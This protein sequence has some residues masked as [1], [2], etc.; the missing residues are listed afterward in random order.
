MTTGNLVLTTS[1]FPVNSNVW[2]DQ[3]NLQLCRC[4]ECLNCIGLAYVH[5]PDLWPRALHLRNAC[6]AV[7]NL[8]STYTYVSCPAYMKVMLRPWADTMKIGTI[9]AG[10][11][12]S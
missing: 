11:T 5:V 2:V 6:R 3:T 9:T 7:R 12:K 1:K 4:Q 8:H 10:E